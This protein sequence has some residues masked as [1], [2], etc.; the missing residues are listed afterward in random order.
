MNENIIHTPSNSLY[1]PDDNSLGII[2]LEKMELHKNKI[3]QVS[4]LVLE[5]CRA[6]SK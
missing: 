5:N 1:E 6:A 2:L 4:T 3:S